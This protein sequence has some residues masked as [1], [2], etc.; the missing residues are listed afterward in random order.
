MQNCSVKLH[1]V[2]QNGTKRFEAADTVD[3]VI[4][5]SVNKYIKCERISVRTFWRTHGRGN[6]DHGENADCFISGQDFEPGEYQFKKSFEIF[7]GPATFHGYFINLDW[8]AEVT[9]HGEDSIILKKEQTFLVDEKRKSDPFPI[10]RQ[11]FDGLP[12]V[13]VEMQLFKSREFVLGVFFFFTTSVVAIS[14]F[15]NF[16]LLPGVFFSIFILLFLR[17]RPCENPFKYFVFDISSSTVNAGQNLDVGISFH[18]KISVPI[19]NAVLILVG[20][21]IVRNRNATLEKRE[22]FRHEFEFCGPTQ[23]V[24]NALNRTQKTITIPANLP[25]SLDVVH[26]ELRWELGVLVRT[27]GFGQ[28][29]EKRRL[30]IL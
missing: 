12:N 23:S 30:T 19:Q 3:L 22:S 5:L 7:S 25:V 6:I 11:V 17:N 15:S 28:K 4:S 18:P 2:N 8:F 27:V 24:S 29:Y 16:A 20:Y 10:T 13:A 9:I 26:N 1:P 14:N 21:E